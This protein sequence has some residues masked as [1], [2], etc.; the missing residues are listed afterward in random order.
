MLFF[1]HTLPLDFPKEAYV[2]QGPGVSDPTSNANI[3]ITF[4]ARIVQLKQIMEN[5]LLSIV[6]I[7][8]LKQI[9][10]W[11][12]RRTMNPIKVKSTSKFG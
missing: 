9:K 10:F 11:R 3:G 7:I 4:L 2:D 8:S 1:K 12:W 6:L 5:L